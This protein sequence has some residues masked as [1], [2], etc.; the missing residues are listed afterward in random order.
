MRDLG[1][2]AVFLAISDLAG[3]QDLDRCAVLA[4]SFR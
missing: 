4:A 3:A 2:D 1:V